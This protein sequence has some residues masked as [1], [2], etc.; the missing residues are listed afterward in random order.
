METNNILLGGDVWFNYR[1]P[2]LFYRKS[3]KFMELDVFV[4]SLNIAF[5][6]QGLQHFEWQVI[7][8]LHVIL[9]TSD[10]KYPLL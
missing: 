8:T 1:H 9:Q 4:P 2:S 5:E 7:M 6:Y 10:N 3:G